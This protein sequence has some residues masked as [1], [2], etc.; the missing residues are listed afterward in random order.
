MTTVWLIWIVPP[1]VKVLAS[2]RQSVAVAVLV[3]AAAVL[4]W[5]VRTI[6]RRG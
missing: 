2:P 5:L 6:R 4:T 3:T 1:G